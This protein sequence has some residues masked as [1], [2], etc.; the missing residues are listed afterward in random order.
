MDPA[1]KT[2][3]CTALKVL[4]ENM[5]KLLSGCCNR[6]TVSTYF[7]PK[8]SK[9]CSESFCLRDPSSS[10]LPLWV[11]KSL[12]PTC[13][14]H[15]AKVHTHRDCKKS[16]PSIVC[17]IGLIFASI[18]D[19]LIQ[20]YLA[21]KQSRQRT[22]HDTYPSTRHPAEGILRCIW[23]I[24]TTKEWDTYATDKKMSLPRQAKHA[25]STIRHIFRWWITFRS[26]LLGFCHFLACRSVCRLVD[27]WL[28]FILRHVEWQIQ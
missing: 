26:V 9:R 27:S 4:D 23:S 17:I 13:E 14:Q 16:V 20:N 1:N 3:H 11:R 25:T 19:Y 7:R 8:L 6:T 28:T 18:C 5:L 2:I 12:L 21:D 22:R 24:W 15:T 10:P